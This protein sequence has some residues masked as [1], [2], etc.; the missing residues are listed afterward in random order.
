MHGKPSPPLPPAHLSTGPS[1]QPVQMKPDCALPATATANCLQLET[2][3]Y[4]VC[5]TFNLNLHSVPVPLNYNGPGSPV[6]PIMKLCGTTMET[7]RLLPL[8]PTQTLSSGTSQKIQFIMSLFGQEKMDSPEGE[9]PPF[10]FSRIRVTA[11]TPF[12]IMT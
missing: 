3:E 7:C 12:T 6:L 11:K 9:R 2:F 4:L 5:R 10:L 1:L 8:L